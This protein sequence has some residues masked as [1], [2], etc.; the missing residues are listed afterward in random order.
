M[1][2]ASL[3]IL[4]ADIAQQGMLLRI[5]IGITA[6]AAIALV[7][8]LRAFLNSYN[9]ERGK[10][11]AQRDDLSSI[12]AVLATQ[13]EIVESIKHGMEFDTWHKKEENQLLRVKL[14][15]LAFH[16]RAF[17]NDFASASH[18]RVKGTRNPDASGSDA[19]AKFTSLMGLYF[20]ELN[21]VSGALLDEAAALE[22]VCEAILLARIKRSNIDRT[23]RDSESIKNDLAN[24]LLQVAATEEELERYRR[25]SARF[26][27]AGVKITLQIYRIMENLLPNAA[28]RPRRSDRSPG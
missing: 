12:K 18:S 15:E 19:V 26:T 6:V 24:A 9:S 7:L 4:L 17:V 21:D 14:E 11:Q 13:T 25:Q 1:I 20:P 2:D 16:C 5:L 28:G 8:G 3:Q 27:E 23:P 22:E 10:L